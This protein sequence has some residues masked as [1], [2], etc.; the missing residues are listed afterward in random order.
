MRSQGRNAAPKTKRGRQE[1]YREPQ[2]TG[3]ETQEQ[4]PPQ[5]LLLLLSILFEKIFQH[6]L[7]AGIIVLNPPL[8]PFKVCLIGIRDLG[9]YPSP[10]NQSSFNKIH[11]I[12]THV[13]VLPHNSAPLFDISNV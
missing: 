6:N 7:G 8:T 3:A 1:D 12:P 2:L 4:K 13:K 11:V 9:S 10:L 5:D